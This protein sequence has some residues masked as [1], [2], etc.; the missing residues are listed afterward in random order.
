VGGGTSIRAVA[1]GPVVLSPPAGG[2]GGAP[3][4]PH[5]CPAEQVAVGFIVRA[6][7]D[8]DAVTMKCAPVTSFAVSV[9]GIRG[10]TGSVTL[11]ATAGNP[12]GG[13]PNDLCCAAGSLVTSVEGTFTGS[14]NAMR[15]RCTPIGGGPTNATPFAG[16]PRPAGTSFTSEC[17]NGANATAAT[18]FQGRSGL[19][20]DQIRL[21]C[22]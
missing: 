15:A 2:S 1:F 4:G 12:S 7:N 13:T 5:S 10:T 22:Q 19:L 8:V 3:F 9:A 11:T 20:V 21:R 14:I 17:P 16:T 6:G 18:G